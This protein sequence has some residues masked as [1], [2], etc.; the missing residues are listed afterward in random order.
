MLI[1]WHD[2]QGIEV[3]SANTDGIV[4]RCERSKIP[5]SESIIQYWQK[6]IG[7]KMET[8]DYRAIYSRDVNNYFAIKE[9]GEVK[10]KGEYSMA[11]LIEKKNPDAEICSDAVAEFLSKGTP[12]LYS[13]AACRDIRKHSR[14]PT[15][16]SEFPSR[17]G[18]A[19]SVRRAVAP[20]NPAIHFFHA[21]N[22]RYLLRTHLATC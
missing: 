13:I 4:I 2:L 21:G 22:S 5:M 6:T 3:I 10:R 9:N 12:I 15:D 20:P 18:R 19:N 17:T 11:G 1:E 8:T 14:C 7:L 16:L